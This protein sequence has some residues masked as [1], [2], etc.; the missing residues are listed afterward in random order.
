MSALS[1]QVPFPVFQDRDG[2]PLDNGYV[3]LGTSSLNPQTNPVVAYYDSALTIVATQP[4]RT[5]NGF[6]SRAGSPAQVYVDAVNFSILVQDSKGTTVFSVPE[7]TGISPN[8]SGVV[9]DPAGTGAVATTVQAKLRESVSVKDFGAVGDGVTDDTAAIQAC[10]N[11]NK[12]V[13]IPRGKYN[14]T[15]PLQYKSGHVIRGEGIA[16]KGYYSGAYTAFSAGTEI[17]LSG[18]ITAFSAIGELSN[19]NCIGAEISDMSFSVGSINAGSASGALPNYLASSVAIDITGVK[20]GSFHDLGF[21]NVDVGLLSRSTAIAAVQHT[22]RDNIYNIVASDVNKVVSLLP[23]T[24]TSAHADMTFSG[25]T[26]VIHCG[27][28]LSLYDCDGFTVDSSTIFQCYGNS[29]YAE[30][31]NFVNIAGCKFFETGGANLH[32]KGCNYI[33]VEATVARAGW[34]TVSPSTGIVIENTT[35]ASL[36]VQ[37]ERPRGIGISVLSSYDVNINCNILEPAYLVGG[38]SGVYLNAS[39]RVAINGSIKVGTATYAVNSAAG[40]SAVSGKLSTD[41]L[42]VGGCRDLHTSDEAWFEHVKPTSGAGVGPGGSL[43]IARKR[44]IV[45]N[46]QNVVLT[47][48]SLYLAAGLKLRVDGYYSPSAA[49]GED[50]TVQALYTNS[51]GSAQIYDM[52]IYI[53]NP[54]GGALTC[55]SMDSVCVKAKIAA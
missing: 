26:S 31:C 13:R 54:T 46:G 24:S 28:A 4:L 34:Y 1:I 35:L 23:K 42:V 36:N 18:A 20:D 7:G 21:F 10:L 51:T 53:Y 3:W 11:G 49:L 33:N 48:A 22:A 6:I 17:I 50:D 9:Y 19:N 37:V 40:S 47:Y 39:N 27:T 55:G 32:F 15:S 41:G 2:Q 5:L 14:V 29:V 12:Y 43:E 8:A 44:F 25:F 30:N 52:S 16:N 38:S 45:P